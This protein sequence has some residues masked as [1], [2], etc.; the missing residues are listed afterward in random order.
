M[1]LQKKWIL[2]M[3][4]MSCVT[5][6]VLIFTIPQPVNHS[7]ESL[8]E[9]DSIINKV[10]SSIDAEER[11]VRRTN[12]V[13]DSLF[14]RKHYHITTSKDFPITAFHAQVALPLQEK[15]VFVTGTRQFPERTLRLRFIYG[16]TVVRTL[17]L[18]PSL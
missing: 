13:V 16:N 9:I 3:L 15:K 11:I 4:M 2:L 14:T 8:D 17:E 7:L 1:E 6:A 5:T 12:F 18:N 10:L